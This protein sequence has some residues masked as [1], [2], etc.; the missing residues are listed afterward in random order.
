VLD[1]RFSL[2]ENFPT[3]N[4]LRFPLFPPVNDF[5][6]CQVFHSIRENEKQIGVLGRQE[7]EGGVSTDHTIKSSKG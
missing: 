4:C 2:T 1:F 7:N 5:N 3:E 6:S